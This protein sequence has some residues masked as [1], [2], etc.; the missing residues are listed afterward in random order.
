[1]GNKPLP[2]GV[3]GA[4]IVFALLIIVVFL[5]ILRPSGSS[6]DLPVSPSSSDVTSATIIYNFYG[7]VKEVKDL[8][9]NRKQ[10]T[11]DTQNKSIPQMTITENTQVF[12]VKQDANGKRQFTRVGK[13]FLK[14]GQNVAVIEWY[15]IKSKKWSTQ[16]IYIQS[17]KP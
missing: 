8:D 16:Y 11:L 13:T 12:D 4:A 10:I 14:N 9:N 6:N 15:D 3:I 17:F 5:V 7:K 1:M 2:L